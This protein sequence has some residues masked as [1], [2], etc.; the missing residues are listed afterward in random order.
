MRQWL[1]AT[2]MIYFVLVCIPNFTPI[3][4]AQQANTTTLSVAGLNEPVTVRRDERGI[5]YIEAKNDHDLYFAQG[6]VT[7]GDRLWQMDLFRR[8]ARGELSEVLGS[9]VL[10][11]DKR[12]RTFGF[13]QTADA[14]LAQATPEARQVLE[15]F[16]AGV[17]AYISSLDP[18]SLPPEFQVLQYKPTPWLP[19]DTLIVVKNFFEALSSTW[20]LDIMRQGFADLPAEKRAA[21]LP[22]RSPLDVL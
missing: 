16:A 17:N 18:K 14:E 10:E 1:A 7:A 11:E 13:A 12:H 22:E 20:R 3:A 19:T 4:S 9:T 15:A 6:Y 21:M 8:N 2:V 5:P